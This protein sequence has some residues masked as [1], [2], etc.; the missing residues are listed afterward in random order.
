GLSREDGPYSVRVFDGGDREFALFEAPSVQPEGCAR[1]HSGFSRSFEG[2]WSHGSL[3]GFRPARMDLAKGRRRLFLR[4]IPPAWSFR[5]AYS[6]SRSHFGFARSWSS[7][8][9]GDGVR[10]ENK[11]GNPADLLRRR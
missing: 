6:R 7:D 4:R 3:R 11:K 1:S 10:R 9:D 8:R 2:P 5:S